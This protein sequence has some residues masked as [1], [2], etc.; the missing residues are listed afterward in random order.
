MFA[1]VNTGAAARSRRHTSFLLRIR[2]HRQECLCHDWLRSWVEQT[3][4]SVGLAGAW[5]CAFEPTGRNACVTALPLRSS[6]R[7]F[8]PSSPRV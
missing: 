5:R 3:F 6:D 7:K 2:T 1:S 4:L 8:H